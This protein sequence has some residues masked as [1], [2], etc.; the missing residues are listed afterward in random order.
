VA[1]EMGLGKTFEVLALVL[2]NPPTA[3]WAQGNKHCGATLVIVPTNLVGQWSL[4]VATKAPGIKCVEWKDADA[5]RRAVARQDQGDAPTIVLASYHKAADIA[6]SGLEFWR[7]VCDEPHLVHP[8]T[9][10][11]D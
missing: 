11:S 9:Q 3:I 10:L 6:R 2:A 4:E 8:V 5:V 1:E 7:V